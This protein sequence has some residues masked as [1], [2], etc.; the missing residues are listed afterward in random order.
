MHKY[1]DGTAWQPS[2]AAF[3]SLGGY[4]DVNTVLAATV[5]GANLIDDSARR[6]IA[7]TSIT[8]TGLDLAGSLDISENIDD[9]TTSLSSGGRTLAPVGLGVSRSNLA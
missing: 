6:R 9:G 1:Y 5:N 4:W 3:E 8:S 7:T 2:S